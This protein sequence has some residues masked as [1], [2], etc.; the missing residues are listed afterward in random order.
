MAEARRRQH[1]RASAE[2]NRNKVGKVTISKVEEIA[3]IKLC[4]FNNTIWVPSYA[5]RDGYGAQHGQAL[6]SGSLEV[7][8]A[9]KGRRGQ[10]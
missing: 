10:R 4:R 9:N 8:G 6:T 7:H 1:A 2:P 5:H 3:K